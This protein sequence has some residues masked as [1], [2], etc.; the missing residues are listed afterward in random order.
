MQALATG[1]DFHTSKQQIEALCSLVD[2]ARRCVKGPAGE[3][4]PN[5]ENG[6]NSRFLLR[7]RAELPLSL[8]IE[9]VRQIRPSEVLLQKLKASAEFPQ[10]NLK[11]GRKRVNSILPE[12]IAVLAHEPV[13]HIRQQLALD[14]DDIFRAVNK[15]NLEVQRIILS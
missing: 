5:H 3:R 14:L 9:V 2:S 13:K 15:A 8:R 6:G 11:H 4:K 10:R 12:N 7:K 1:G